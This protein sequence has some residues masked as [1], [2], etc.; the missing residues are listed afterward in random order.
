[1]LASLLIAFSTSVPLV[2]VGRI[3]INNFFSVPPLQITKS[4]DV[5]QSLISTLGA[6]SK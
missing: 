3:I 1:M 5:I 6:T 4:K 2:G